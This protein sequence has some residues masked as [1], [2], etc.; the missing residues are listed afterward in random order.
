VQDRPAHDRRYAV[1]S[2]KLQTE[3]GWRP[4]VGFSSGLAETIQWFAE[5]EAW[6]QSI[7]SVEYHRYYEMHYGAFE[8]EMVEAS[9]K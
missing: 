4:Q 9:A 8:G 6:W 5:N 3:L 7:M 2:T 1:S